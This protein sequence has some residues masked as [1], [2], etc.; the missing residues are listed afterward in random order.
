MRF[1]GQYTEEVKKVLTASIL[2]GQNA[3]LIS[4]PGMGKTEMMIEVAHRIAGEDATLIIKMTPSTPPEVI[5]GPYDPKAYLD[6]RY[7]RI[8]H[9]TPYDPNK[10][11]ICLDEL[12]RANDLSFDAG[13]HALD[14][15]GIDFIN[16]PVAW[17]TSNFVVKAERFD[18]LRDRFAL[19][20]YIRAQ[21]AIRSVLEAHADNIKGLD[22]WASDLPSLSDCQDVRRMQP[23]PK[24]QEAIAAQ[25]EV[26]AQEATQ[27]GFVV[28]NRRLVQ[29]FDLLFY[30]GAYYTG[31]NDFSTIPDKSL[32]LL[33]YAYPAVDESQAKKWAGVALACMDTIGSRIDA[34]KSQAYEKFQA[35]TSE[36]DP[37]R[38]TS[39]ILEMGNLL[40]VVQKEL[41]E[42]AG[43]DPRAKE[44]ASQM[45]VWFGKACAG[46]SL[47][48]N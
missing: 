38:K 10:R 35:L 42:I 6:G 3:A 16:K 33:Q 39:L 13:I 46:K 45:S 31:S 8:T 9:N 28:N 40:Q 43:D 11:V 21:V 32:S 36:K 7:E 27:E 2:S 15:K 5:E 20:F 26:L 17:A 25:I 23:G 19:F 12:W 47:D 37:S 41:V 44:A 22:G 48:E 1:A 18:A 4:Q 14:Q 24:A 29:W 30:T 34:I